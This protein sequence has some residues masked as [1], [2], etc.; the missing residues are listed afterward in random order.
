MMLVG[1]GPRQGETILPLADALSL[2][3]RRSGTKAPKDGA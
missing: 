1:G 2:E 3:L